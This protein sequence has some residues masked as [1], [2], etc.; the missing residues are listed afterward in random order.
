MILKNLI[1]KNYDRSIYFKDYL[2]IS[3]FLS[4]FFLWDVKINLYQNF[5]ISLREIFY[6]LFIYL[7]IN[8]K[9]TYNPLFI[10]TFLFIVVLLTHS[11]LSQLPLSF[12]LLDFKYNLLPILF[13]FFIF[14]ICYVYIEE[15]NKNL[16]LVFIIFIYILFFSFF[17]TDVKNMTY[18][19][20]VRACSFASF[21][22]IN[23]KIFL[24]A[25][26]LGMILIP[27]YY[28]IF[29]V[30][31][32]NF[33]HKVSFL[34][35]LLF[36][37][38]FYSS[39]T[40]VFSAIICFVLALFIDYRF[41][42]K[43]KLFLFFQVLILLLPIFKNS[44]MFKVNVA[45][46][47]LNK[48]NIVQNNSNNEFFSLRET[49]SSLSSFHT[50]DTITPSF[51]EIYNYNYNEDLALKL[52]LERD[53]IRIIKLI[54]TTQ[55]NLSAL[56]LPLERNEKIPISKVNELINLAEDTIQT[57]NILEKTIELINRLKRNE[58]EDEA[59]KAKIFK[60]SQE[61][62]LKLKIHYHNL[63]KVRGFYIKKNI[64]HK[65][66][67]KSSKEINDIIIKNV[68]F[69]PIHKPKY[70]RDHS[71]AVLLNAI[72]VA[73][74]SIKDKPLGWG[75]NNY[76]T[77][78]N[79]YVLDKITPSFYEIYY[80]NYN[81]ASNNSIKLIVEFGVFVLIIFANLLYFVF[82]KKI[83]SSQRLL[84][85]GIIATQMFR[86]AGYFNGGFILC[87]II[88]FILNYKSLTKNE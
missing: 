70:I 15:M 31:N 51:Y 61:D 88:T 13:I 77:A 64:L 48:D 52:S 20:L 7:L 6:V 23:N 55:E 60:E 39:I 41:F 78:F 22:L 26:H 66:N 63:V 83:P 28:Y 50:K 16:N 1:L 11:Y 47:G 25:S 79:K 19:E 68:H 43:N 42:I 21:K 12:T 30:N 58:I 8:Y 10:K 87:L 2:I 49:K 56:K 38:L 33:F 85:G 74:Y 3:S 32:L 34:L 82:N 59:Q 57:V 75:L 71:S 86:A 62:L 14:L 4:F 24:E 36:I 80:L 9:K 53:E 65:H 27:I 18:N 5:V 29:K 44:C 84:F 76:Q 46:I 35:F 54:E 37:V 81:D 67:Q 17:F 40:L 45:L 69:L 72:T 73:Y